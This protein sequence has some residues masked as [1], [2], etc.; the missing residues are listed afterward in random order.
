MGG[1]VEGVLLFQLSWIR[2][3]F[4]DVSGCPSQLIWQ[5]SHGG[6]GK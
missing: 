5:F 6:T 2:G 4:R 1:G 3:V